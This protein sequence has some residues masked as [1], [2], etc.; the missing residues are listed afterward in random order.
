MQEGIIGGMAEVVDGDDAVGECARD[1]GDGAAGESRDRG[2][3]VR[4][5]EVVGWDALGLIGE[6]F[7]LSDYRPSSSETHPFSFVSLLLQREHIQNAYVYPHSD[8]QCF[9]ISQ[10]PYSAEESS[11]DVFK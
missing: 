11:K 10:N 6:I 9:L 8:L 5:G 1:G 4:T 3:G 2:G 7:P